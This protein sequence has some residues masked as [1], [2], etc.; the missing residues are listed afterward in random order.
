MPI[1]ECCK[2]ENN[3]KLVERTEDRIIMKC[4][5]CESRHIRVKIDP[6]DMIWKREK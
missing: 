4:I 5:V 2:D 3:L 1:K 6:G